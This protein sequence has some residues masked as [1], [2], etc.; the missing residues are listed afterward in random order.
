MSRRV[1]NS[2]LVIAATA[3]AVEAVTG[4]HSD[5]PRHEHS[6]QPPLN[7]LRAYRRAPVKA[8]TPGSAHEVLYR[9][10]VAYGDLSPATAEQR[11]LTLAS[12]A[13]PP[14]NTVFLRA[15]R[16]AKNQ[17]TRGLLPGEQ[18]KARVA[19][20]ALGAENNAQ[21][22]ASVVL[23][24]RLIHRNGT[25]EP[26]VQTAFVATLADSGAGWRVSQFNPVP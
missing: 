15:A 24:Q 25:S 5:A 1:R 2:L 20:L 22:R 16:A 18:L 4:A 6:T 7:A 14:L 26:A 17:A 3:I 8:G 10:A 11:A 13:V 9:F 21:R 12:L 19:S 23:E